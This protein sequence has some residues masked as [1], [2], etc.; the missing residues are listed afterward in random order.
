[1]PTLTPFSLLTSVALGPVARHLQ[2]A[3]LLLALP[4]LPR[5]GSLTA[6]AD[7]LAPS[8]TFSAGHFLRRAALASCLSL[9]RILTEIVSVELYLSGHR[10]LPPRQTPHL[11]AVSHLPEASSSSPPPPPV[12]PP[13]SGAPPPMLPKMSLNPVRQS[14]GPQRSTRSLSAAG[15]HSPDWCSCPSLDTG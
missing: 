12:P 5:P 14:E 11:P 2:G 6:G 1:M 8:T 13:S 3:R 7:S 10:C 9:T 15:G 4:R